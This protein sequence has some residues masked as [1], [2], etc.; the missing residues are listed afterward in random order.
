MTIIT[1][2]LSASATVTG[3]VEAT[4][5]AKLTERER[6]ILQEMAQ[7]KSNRQIADE[8]HLAKGTVKNYVSAI[9]G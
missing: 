4:R 9:I 7:G 8:L 2:N 5:E 1:G 3:H 6:S